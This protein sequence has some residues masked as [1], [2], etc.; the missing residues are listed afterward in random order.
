VIAPRLFVCS[1][2]EVA[3]T[4]PISVGRTRIDLDSLGP[5]ANVHVSLEDVAKVLLKDISPRLTDLLEIASYVFTADTATARGEG[6]SNDYTVE[7]WSRDFQFVIPV[8]DP[9]FWNRPEILQ[10]LTRVLNFLSNDRYSFQFPALRLDR[11][12]QLYLEFGNR[13][14]WPFHNVDRVIMFSGGLDS[15][16]GAVETAEKGGK[17]V[18]VSHRSVGTMDKRQR[19]LFQR[20]SKLYPN[21]LFHVPVWINKEKKLGREHTQRTRS[22]LYSALGV[23]IAQSVNA[24]GVRF[25]ENGI[26]S[27]NLP[28]AD[29]VTQAR[30]SRTTHPWALHLFE[31]LYRE[32]TGKAISVDNP[33]ISK[34]KAEVITVLKDLGRGD[35]ISMT[36][37]CAHT[38]FFQ[39]KTQWHCG[40]CSQCIDRRVAVFAS[41]TQEFDPAIDYVSDVFVGPRKDGYEKNMAVNFAR[42]ASELHRMSESE[43]AATFN[44][45]FSRAARPFAQR[46]KSI[47]G[48][49]EM[50]K[51]HGA[52]VLDVLERMLKENVP[53][54]LD[55]SLDKN[56][57]L[58]LMYGGAHQESS[59]VQ[60]AD[61]IHDLLR[62]GLPTACKSHKPKDEPH[63]QEIADGIL[64]GQASDLVREFP[65]MRWSS[66]LTKPD[67]SS[68]EFR[69]WVEMKYVRKR[70][71]IRPITSAIAE[72]I[73][74]YGDN[75]RR[76]LFLIYDPSHLIVDQEAFAHPVALRPTMF[77]RFIN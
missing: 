37:S 43:I 6:W 48:F 41:G 25:F 72:D 47:E 30:A 34:T 62:R 44:A 42:H 24:G 77:T 33:F 11:P 52:A 73:T 59:W 31:K 75:G 74:K 61:R 22:F 39:S 56:C 60:F 16:A 23:V 53:S 1:G 7:A 65:F 32:I 76:V 14:D 12:A 50:H 29:E 9:E 10:D 3:E 66:V 21:Q 35:L 28:I 27:L 57:L 67:W 26:V 15:L 51:R 40:T 55:S 46:G 49:V 58:K 18:L 69:L 2:A 4:D 20:L 63:L 70:E 5:N 8:R 19:L 68:E 54:L 64:S 36:C 38:G 13:N 45:E 71:D 17:L